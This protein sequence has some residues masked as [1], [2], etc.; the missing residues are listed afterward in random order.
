MVDQARAQQI[1]QWQ[2]RPV[3]LVAEQPGLVEPTRRIDSRDLIKT[4][5]RELVLQP[6]I[7]QDEAYVHDEG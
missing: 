5:A 2:P 3:R 4:P 6:T 7:D 1:P